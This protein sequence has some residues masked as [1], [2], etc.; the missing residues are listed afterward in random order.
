M[1]EIIYVDASGDEFT[2]SQLIEL[3]EKNGKSVEEF[4]S[5]IGA[6]L[7][8]SEEVKKEPISKATQ[9]A[10]AGSK[11]NNAPDV[12]EPFS[13]N[14]STVSLD[15]FL[16]N[17]SD[18]AGDETDVV[19]NINRKLSQVGLS[20]TEGTAW[21]SLDA[22]NLSKFNAKGFEDD[23]E[24]IPL[25]GIEALMQ[26]I[27][28][29]DDDDL[30]DSAEKINEYIKNNGNPNYLNEANVRSA[31]VFEEYNKYIKAPEIENLESEYW[32]SKRNKFKNIKEKKR[33]KN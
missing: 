32:Q 11:E 2:E 15:K 6:V 19:K 8:Q 7:K 17:A 26:G 14:T 9:G 27:S 21:G 31:G 24:L 16:V 10:A 33:K 13:V 4:K 28:V 12:M 25:L 3:A 18:L 29:S 5:L 20:S 1:T 30:V 23:G 22:I